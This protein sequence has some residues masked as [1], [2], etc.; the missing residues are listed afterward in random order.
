MTEDHTLFTEISPHGT[1][2]ALVEQND[3]VAHFYLRPLSNPEFGVRSCWIRNLKKA[4]WFLDV[5]GM[6]RGIS[7][8]LP[9]K[10]CRHPKGAEP[11]RAQDMRVIW[12]PSGDGA[13]LEVNREILAV[14][15]PWSG[16]NG[17]HGY[18]R[19]CK[20]LSPLCWDLLPAEKTILEHYREAD[21]YWQSWS[22]SSSPWQIY[23]T[24]CLAALESK[25]GQHRRYFAI[26]GG[27]WPPK[28]LAVY[29]AQE[30]IILV[31]IGVALRPQ[32]QVEM[33]CEEPDLD[34]RFEFALGLS[35]WTPDPAVER[36]ASYMSGQ[37]NLPWHK[38][39]FV[40]D[41]HTIP[42]DSLPRG[43]HDQEFPAVLLSSSPPGA[44]QVSLPTV[45]GDP[46]NL[47]W[48]IP[49]TQTERTYAMKESS[50]ALAEEL[51]RSTDAW[52]CGRR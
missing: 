10:Y 17:F 19:D 12:L 30:S 11:L 4:P 44:P 9:K 24:A 48:M 25:L 46:V 39:T 1:M 47:L 38:F 43:A 31:T 26:D 15:P 33:Y 27:E 2:E 37:T 22:E 40:A 51:F 5:D 7:P 3:R 49:I 28:A 14:I 35:A 23:Q 50:A 36:C 18:A 6:K 45:D 13:A 29:S 34:R 8:M 52:C 20:D 41:S 32:P 21:R 42:C 16:Q